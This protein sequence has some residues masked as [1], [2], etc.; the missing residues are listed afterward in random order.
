M[1]KIGAI[2]CFSDYVVTRRLV[3]L[4]G[5]GQAWGKVLLSQHV[6][7][8]CTHVRTYVR[9]YVRTLKQNWQLKNDDG[10]CLKR[11][12]VKFEV[13]AGE[14]QWVN[15]RLKFGVR[16]LATLNNAVCDVRQ[17]RTYERTYA[18]TSVRPYVRTYV[19]TDFWI[20]GFAVFRIFGFAD[21]RIFGFLDCRIFCFFWICQFLGFWF[22]YFWIF[23]FGVFGRLDFRIFGF[24][25]FCHDHGH[26]HG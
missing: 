15:G 13:V 12:L 2:L 20:S 23:G 24:L 6:L 18:R 9:T 19:R 1:T 8:V 11:V 21:F 16:P 5:V 22:S 25:D 17:R 26:D 14:F 3:E 7:Y 10:G 4:S